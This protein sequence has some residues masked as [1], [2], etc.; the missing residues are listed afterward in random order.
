M[1]YQKMW[2]ELKQFLSSGAEVNVTVYIICNKMN[3][4]ES[5]NTRRQH[6]T[7]KN[8]YSKENA[9][10]ADTTDDESTLDS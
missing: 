2:N 10:K 4:L 9:P 8:P 5:E 6:S 7:D 3:E 1:D